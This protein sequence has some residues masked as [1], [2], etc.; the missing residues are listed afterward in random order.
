MT[1]RM[2][3][4]SHSGGQGVTAETSGAMME[5]AG[6]SGGTAAFPGGSKQQKEGKGMKLRLASPADSD[7][8]RE[9]YAQYID[10][11]VTFEYALPSREEFARR[12]ETISAD[13]PYLVCE[14]E[15]EIVGYA[16]AHRQMERAAYQWN[17]ELSIY[18]DREHTSRG[19][20]KTLAGALLELLRRQG[21]KTVYSGVTLPN[22][23]SEGLH[24]SL[25]FRRLGVYRRTGY[26]CGKWHDVAWFE[27]AIAPYEP[28]PAPVR[29]LRE[30]PEEVVCRVL[31]G[32]G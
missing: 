28:A 19:L 2:T 27:K 5:K 3:I 10:T 29:S 26:K 1:G 25:G 12:V 30:M 13:Y 16:Y 32:Q 4:P 24:A 8:L 17:A 6:G 22:A 14:Q 15:E 20:G 9:I 18:I 7:A 11:P 21:V 23:R 31:S